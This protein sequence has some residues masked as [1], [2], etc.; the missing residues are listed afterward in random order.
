MN[1]VW[2]AAAYEEAPVG[3]TGNRSS[4]FSRVSPPVE[5]RYLRV[6]V[7][8]S[9]GGGG[10]QL[11]RDKIA[12]NAVFPAKYEKVSGDNGGGRLAGARPGPG[13]VFSPSAP[14]FLPRLPLSRN[15]IGPMSVGLL[16][17]RLC[18]NVARIINDPRSKAHEAARH[19]R[20]NA[21][22]PTGSE[23]V[24]IKRYSRE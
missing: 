18:D 5:N 7:V 21:A 24:N 19:G 20:G 11:N 1:E 14:L 15:I 17:V 22:R 13:C 10:G 2:E 23:G 8:Y 6:V 9:T 16:S 4:S 3:D 12:D